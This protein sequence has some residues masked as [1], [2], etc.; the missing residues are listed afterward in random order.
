MSNIN[1]RA[2]ICA[3]VLVVAM[4]WPHVAP[5]LPI[6]TEPSYVHDAAWWQEHCFEETEDAEFC[7]YEIVAE[8]H[9]WDAV[10]YTLEE[11]VK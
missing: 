5:Y 11:I 10:W 1:W 9:G 6:K 3:N 2:S 4:I 8:Y 7:G